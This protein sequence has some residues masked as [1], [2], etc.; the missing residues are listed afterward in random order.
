MRFLFMIIAAAMLTSCASTRRATSSRDTRDSTRIISQQVDS[1]YRQLMQRDSIYYRDSIYI[2]EKGDTV[3]YYIERL[4]YAYKIK[5]DTIYTYKLKRDTVY[6]VRTDSIRV[7][8][9]TY[10]EKPCA[11]TAY[12]LRYLPISRSR[13]NG[14]TPG[15]YGWA[16]CAA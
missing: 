14:T 12:A 7:T 16:V 2:K 10:I 15:L 11:R 1:I 4:R 5:T 13:E 8:V 9:P 3:T 6:A